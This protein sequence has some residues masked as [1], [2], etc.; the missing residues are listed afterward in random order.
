[1][2]LDQEAGQQEVIQQIS[3]PETVVEGQVKRTYLR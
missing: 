2:D 3:Q 1:M